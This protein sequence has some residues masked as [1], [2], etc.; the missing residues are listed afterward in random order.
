MRVAAGE[1]D[2][3]QPLAAPTSGGAVATMTIESSTPSRVELELALRAAVLQASPSEHGR[4][5][6]RRA[7][8]ALV[9]GL[10]SLAGVVA[11]FDLFLLVRAG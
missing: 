11:V 4:E 1:G 6:A 10:A 8:H 5:R 7:T 2:G 3:T 9:N